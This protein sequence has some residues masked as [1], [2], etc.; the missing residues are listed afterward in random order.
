MTPAAAASAV[1]ALRKDAREYAEM[2]RQAREA[3]DRIEKFCPEHAEYVKAIPVRADDRP[4]ILFNGDASR[5]NG[6]YFR[7]GLEERTYKVRGEEKVDRS[8]VIMC[9]TFLRNSI[10]IGLNG[11]VN[12]AGY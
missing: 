11:T 4:L 1:T 5:A 2:A 7:Y 3:A 10:T 8:L 9:P 6:P 12:G